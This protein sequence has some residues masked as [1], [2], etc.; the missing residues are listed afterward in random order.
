VAKLFDERFHHG[1][2]LG[3]ES[4]RRHRS[5]GAEHLHVV[6]GCADLPARVAS[7]VVHRFLDERDAAPARKPGE[8]VLRPLIDEIPTKMRERDDRWMHAGYPKLMCASVERRQMSKGG[9]RVGDPSPA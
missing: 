5:H 3:A 2:L 4:P 8:Q 6:T 9:R 7:R 1:E